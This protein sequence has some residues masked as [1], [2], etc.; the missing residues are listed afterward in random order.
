MRQRNPSRV[1]HPPEG[2]R[3]NSH[4]FKTVGE[5]MNLRNIQ[6]DSMIGLPK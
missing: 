2:P 6:D 5:K 3:C 4:D 1:A